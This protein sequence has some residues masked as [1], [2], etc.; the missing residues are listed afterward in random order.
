MYTCTYMGTLMPYSMKYI[1]AVNFNI[2]TTVS[3]YLTKPTSKWFFLGPEQYTDILY[4]VL[5]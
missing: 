4:T 2:Y 5:R 3:R 1:A